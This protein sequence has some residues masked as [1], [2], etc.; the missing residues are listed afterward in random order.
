MKYM[1]LI[2]GIVFLLS[3]FVLQAN[4]VRVVGDVRVLPSQISG[5]KIASFDVQLEWDNSWRDEV[6]YDA[7]YL[8]LKYRYNESGEVWHHLYL[9]DQV[10]LEGAGG[11]E[12]EYHL[13]NSSGQEDRNEGILVW[14]KDE[15]DGTSSVRLTLTWDITSG[16]RKLDFAAFNRGRVFLSAMGLEMVYV[17]QGAFRAGDSQT[18]SHF[19]HKYMSIPKA[20][21]VTGEQYRFLTKNNTFN[22]A[23][24]P[25]FAVNRM[26]DIDRKT[27]TNAW[28]GDDSADQFWCIDFGAGSSK[29]VQY[30]AIEGI[31]GYVPEE[32]ELWGKNDETGIDEE[33]LYKG[34]G[35]E[36]S[37]TAHQVYPATM[38]LRI[39][40]PHAYRFYELRFTKMGTAKGPVLKTVAMCEKDL[41]KEY[42]N[43]VLITEEQVHF[44]A[45]SGLLLNHLYTDEGED[46]QTGS[47]SVSYPTGYQGFFAMKH[48]IS[49]E[50][51]VTFLNHLGLS[52][53]LMRTQG[54]KMLNL[55]AGQYVFGN[56]PNQPSA[57]NGIVVK[58]CSST[59]D[60][61]VFA[62]DLDKENG[63]YNLNGD[64][65]TIACNFLTPLDML[66]YA[67]WAGLRPLSELEYEK[68]C[69]RPYPEV[70][71]QK[72]FA[73]NTTDLPKSGTLAIGSGG[74]QE[75]SVTGGN[76]NMGNVLS[77]PVRCGAFATGRS[78]QTDAGAGYWGILDLGGNLAELY[79]NIRT[80][81]RVF[82]GASRDAHGNGKLHS[83]TGDS[84]VPANL[85]PING[86]AFALRGGSFKSGRQEL[87]TSD[88]SRSTGVYAA[89]SVQVRMEDV[90]FRLGCTMELKRY[91]NVLTLENG[92]TTAAGSVADTLWTGED[93]VI[94]SDVPE[95]MQGVYHTFAWFYSGDN[96]STWDVI[97]GATGA[98]LSLKNLR[99][100]NVGAAYKDYRYR[101]EIYSCV[102]DAKSNPVI[103]RVMNNTVTV[104]HA[105]MQSNIS[106]PDLG[107]S[108]SSPNL[109]VPKW[110]FRDKAWEEVTFTVT[111][112]K[113]YVHVPV[114]ED[115]EYGDQ[116]QTGRQPLEFSYYYGTYQCPPRDT[117]WVEVLPESGITESPAT[118]T[119]GRPF[120]D[121][122]NERRMIY[123]TVKIGEQCWMSENLNY[124]VEGSKCYNNDSLNCEKYGRLY[125]W[126]Q[127]L[128]RTAGTTVE[129]D[130]GVQGI[131]PDGWHVP[132]QAEWQTL[133]TT[134]GADGKA[135]KSPYWDK[136][137]NTTGFGALAGGGYFY[138]YSSS[139]STA[140][141]IN[142]R[143]G[144]YDMTGD[145]KSGSAPR[146]WWWTS[147]SCPNDRYWAT[148]YYAYQYNYNH[149]AHIPFYVRLD[150]SGRLLFNGEASWRTYGYV[151][152]SVFVSNYLTSS[153]NNSYYHLA[154]NNDNATALLRM[155][156]EFYMSVR[157]IKNE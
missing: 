18:G 152:N 136:A 56:T 148:E 112:G 72:E 79:Y 118:V 102:A 131:C 4:N 19:H 144:F 153:N 51:Y 155:R 22:P 25:Q 24:P 93:Y 110:R 111:A 91:A 88:R 126:F 69:R 128:G 12:Y 66:A 14:R 74:T 116:V 39:S 121:T 32:W 26:N 129:V 105:S 73:W 11:E 106:N 34:T 81:G 55:R 7:V 156:K 23:Y 48:E 68:M 135:V 53:Q 92:L 119:C 65:Q 138:S 150:A 82:A 33:L 103:L 63:G 151:T 6:N 109:I 42:D 21:D 101:C 99:H 143:T 114:F 27:A 157:C 146:G 71:K 75:E 115:F 142:S 35:D 78:S 57:R 17:P 58:D 80:A 10:E 94:H 107:I 86:S 30:F 59:T 123:N 52:Q 54:V 113:S 117:V 38:A 140:A 16:D 50:Q 43:S 133:N 70:P 83:Q 98:D 20:W 77:G 64:G 130:E 41:Q 139:Y 95:V 62:C 147:T 9:G 137:G 154:G 108:F 37:T 100:L 46:M 29:T 3:G 76:A 132:T 145:T 125:N 90:T 87:E 31:P 1:R 84:D 124:A 85:W 120:M 8:F 89:G 44:T 5:G 13:L 40:K 97:E 127:A 122:R 49:Q 60:P 45:Q 67:D 15:G 36:W 149:T 2:Y 28:L 141:G 134:A 104:T 47:A 61:W 96:G